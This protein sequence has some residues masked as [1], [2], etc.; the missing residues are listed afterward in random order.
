MIEKLDKAYIDLSERNI[1]LERMF[2][3]I[4]SGI[5]FIGEGGKIS[6]INKAGEEILQIP[7][8][9]IEGK[10][11]TEILEFIE[12]DEL[13]DFIKKACRRANL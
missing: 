8:D 9:K 1:L 12:S 11:Y 10:H 6:K 4:T 13:R 7:K 5:I 2:S 3:N